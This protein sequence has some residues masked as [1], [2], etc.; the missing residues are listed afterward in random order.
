MANEGIFRE[1]ALE[2]LVA[3]ERLDQG[4][5]IVGRP[6]WVVQLA[7]AVLVAGGLIWSVVLTVPVTVP[8]QG[9][10][11]SPGGLLDVTADNPGRLLSFS[12]AV[13][14]KIKAGTAVA[15]LDQPEIREDLI[16]AEA[17]HRDAVGERD[18]IVK[19][20]ERR[21]PT[22]AASIAQRRQGYKDDIAFLEKQ[23]G[24]L[25]EIAKG[26]AVLMD[27]QILTR[28]S[29]LETRVEIGKAEAQR[30]QAQDGIRNLD[31]EATKAQTDDEHERLNAEL[32]VAAA[33]R[34]I[35][36]VREKLARQSVVLS[37]YD[38]TVIELKV[39]PGEIVDRNAALFSL[40]P[41]RVAEAL[42]KDDKSP[43]GPLY[44]VV[45]VPSNDGKKVRPGMNVRLSPS[46]V[47][48]EE[49]G[50]IEGRV[51]TVAEVPSTAEG[52]YRTLKNRQLGQSLAKDGAPYEVVV[53]LFAAPDTPSGYRW[54]S[55][56]GPDLNINAGT[57]V[58]SDIETMSLPVLSVLIP[59]LR[60][61]LGNGVLGSGVLGSGVL[62]SGS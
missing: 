17:E 20:Q 2:R 32:K 36:T 28:K 21:G 3:P 30:A 22:L 33:E 39:N 61:V 55:S 18:Q 44:A 37:P 5:R 13:G 46:T 56:R 47:R 23:L 11:L 53:D 8:G 40:I 48:R 4:L 12:V 35:R 1:A 29:A 27:K 10:L 45:Y 34:K 52:M 6:T 7:L 19:F 58:G 26:D 41:D 59:P 50:F 9:I 15:R 16:N 51:R 14:D 31:F 62:G 43:I 57:V 54:S 38:G 60:Q 24:W 49:Y 42:P 25:D